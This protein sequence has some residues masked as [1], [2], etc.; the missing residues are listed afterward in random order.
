MGLGKYSSVSLAD[1]RELRDRWRKVLLSGQNPIEV[2]KAIP[3][4][5]PTFGQCAA[6]VIAGQCRAHDYTRAGK[7]RI[8][9]DDEDAR[10]LASTFN[11]LTESGAGSDAGAITTR[12]ERN[13]DSFVINGVKQFITSG[14][15]ADVAI[16]AAFAIWGF[17]FAASPRIPTF[18]PTSVPCFCNRSAS[19]RLVRR[20]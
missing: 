14:K 16:V 3:K 12:A 8:A 19:A 2:R 7:P 17:A 1:A 11:A 5:I 13:G 4:R 6:E 9:W 10:L 20:R 15:T 18:F